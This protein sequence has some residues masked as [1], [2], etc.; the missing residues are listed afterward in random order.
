[1]VKIPT[2]MTATT[3]QQQQQQQH[4]ETHKMLCKREEQRNA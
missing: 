4:I 3:Q 1:M 2:T